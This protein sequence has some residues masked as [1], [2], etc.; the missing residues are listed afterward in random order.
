MLGEL[1]LTWTGRLS[2]PVLEKLLDLPEP[3]FT[4]I[5]TRRDIP[6]R[7]PDGVKLATDHFR[8]PGQD[9]LPA[10]IFRTPYDKQGIISQL[11]A[12][13]LA[14]QGFQVVVQDTRGQFG[15]EGKFDAFR[16]ERADG[17]AT[18]AWVREQPWC[19]GTLATAG[20][21]YLGHTQWA[22]APY[23]EPPLAA[24]CPA[25]TTSNF[26]ELFY[27]GG[28]FNLHNL[29][30]WSAAV[31]SPEI[32]QAVRLLRANA[33]GKR[34]R[35]AMDHLPLA[36]ADNVAIGKPE[37]FWRTVTD[38]ND[39]D[40]W[41]EINHTA[42][43]ATLGTPVSM[44]TGWWDL[45]LVGQLRDYEELQKAGCPRRITIGS[46]DHAKSIKTAIAD[47]FSWLA[48]HLHGDASSTHR[49]PVRVYLQKAGQWLDF[50][51]WPPK[52]STPTPL[53]L[54][55]D[56]GLD[57]QAPQGD[58]A[59]DTFTYDPKDPTPAVGGPLL[60]ARVSGQRDNASIES[61]SDVLVFTTAPLTKD[62]DLVG[63]VSA[64]VYATTDSGQGDLFV[65]LCDVDR[66]GVSRNVTDGIVKLDGAAQSPVQV[67][68]HPTGYRFARGHRLRVQVSGGAFP[69]H[70]RN[71]GSGEPLATASRIVP[72]RFEIRH[73]EGHPS[74]VTLPV[75]NAS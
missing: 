71:T 60:D 21:S 27:P 18:A 59:V 57:W 26:T 7:M 73:D 52:S 8:P 49:A 10:V 75:L 15:S 62:L 67:T 40:Y 31:G 20:P 23:I 48:A 50:D 58:S 56:H 66:K 11:W 6:V 72:I 29:L 34:V 53:Y 16:Q 55:A 36:D 19:D 69:N 17:L 32:P 24:M 37:P 25:I 1:A 51:H 33:H 61:R 38:H 35:R 64:S 28:S 65:R 9:P 74:A 2:A 46:W 22:V 12:T 39:D 4:Q 13:L 70:A 3:Q 45:L 47:S 44:V 30:T 43:L 5:Q 41:D 63:P 68:M 54:Q 14:R 42:Q